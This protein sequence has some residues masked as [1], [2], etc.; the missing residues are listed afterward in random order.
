MSFSNKCF[1]TAT[2]VE[3]LA[4]VT[5]DRIT[6]TRYEQGDGK[7]YGS[8]SIAFPVTNIIT[9]HYRLF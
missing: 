7:H 2:K 1:E 4:A 8:D 6:K 9:I 5:T 3:G